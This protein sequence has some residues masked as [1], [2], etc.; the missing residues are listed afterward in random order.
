MAAFK[1]SVF[2]LVGKNEI[3]QSEN[4]YI[5]AWHISYPI[6]AVNSVN[7]SAEQFQSFQMKGHGSLKQIIKEIGRVSRLKKLKLPPR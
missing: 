4:K 3:D 1:I 2:V 5:L 6:Q 7:N